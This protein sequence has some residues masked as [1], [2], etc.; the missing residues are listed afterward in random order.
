M[1][2]FIL[3]KNIVAVKGAKGEKKLLSRKAR[4]I[5]L[6]ETSVTAFGAGSYV[7]LDFGAELCGEIRILTY[8]SDKTPVRIRFGESVSECCAEL[9][10]D[11]NATNDHSP[12]DF[13]VTLPKYSDLTFGGTGFRF[14]RLDFEGEVSIK[15]VIAINHILKKKA[16]Y[17]YEGNDERIREIFDAAKRTVDL[18]ASGEYL[19]DGVKRDRLVWIGDIHPEMLA[20]TALYGR[21]SVIERSLD[22]VKK[23]TPLPQWMNRF[24]MYSMWWIIIVS[25]YLKYTGAV[26][27]ASRQ[28]D[29]LEGLVGQMLGCVSETGELNY[30]SYFVDWPS[31]DTPDEIHGVRAINIMAAKCAIH[32]LESFGKDTTNAKELLRRLMLKKIAPESAKQI[33]AL[34]HFAVGL[35]K[36]DCEKLTVGG[37]MGMS[38]FMSYYIL[39]AVASFDRSAAIDMMKEYYGAMLDKGATTFFEDFDMSWVKNSSRIDEMPREG[40]RDI[41]G[42]FG[43]YCYRGFRHSLCHG[44]SAGVIRFIMEEC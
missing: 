24:P 8:I 10:G 28:L 25:D 15:S 2:E 39:K 32:L 38:T 20:L 19:W 3:P 7:I 35:D 13:S 22:F 11:K 18:C 41:H 21:V 29:Y 26:D 42:D 9:G 36:P 14:V 30:P 12:R 44:W 37:A 17:T 33:F 23:Q 1:T 34:K 16:L 27:F 31:H 43:A 6:D 5:G 40:E 4:Q